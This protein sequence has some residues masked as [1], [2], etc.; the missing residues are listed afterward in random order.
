MMFLS[1]DPAKCVPYER[2]EYSRDPGAAEGGPGSF[3]LDAA[4][5]SHLFHHTINPS[6]V[7]GIPVDF[8]GGSVRFF[9]FH[10][11]MILFY[12]IANHQSTR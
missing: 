6:A 8:F 9:S 10:I 7:R 2:C 3:F 4:G 5:I 1:V 12:G 11:N